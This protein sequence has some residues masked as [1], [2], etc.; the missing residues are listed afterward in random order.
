MLGD[1][2]AH[3][4]RRS[5]DRRG[6]LALFGGGLLAALGGGCAV[7]PVSG[8]PE[9]VVISAE[10]E[11]R[12][13]QEEADKVEREMGVVDDPRLTTYVEALGRRLAAKSPRADVTYTFRIVDDPEPNAF[14]LP[15]GHVYV[16][17]GLLALVNS[18]D[19]LAG[20][21]GHEIGHVAA[22]HSVQQLSRGA[23]LAV[24]S[25]LGGAIPIVGGVVGGAGRLATAAILAPYSREQEHEAD[26][27]GM[28]LA[29]RG[30]WDPAALGRF[31]EVL[32]REQALHGKA[33]GRAGFLSS[34]PSTP[35]RV[36]SVA[37]RARE[38]TR[39]AQAP[40]TP[41]REA[42]FGRLD[43]L[44]VG[45]RAADGVFD[46]QTF[47]HPDLAFVVSFPKGW[48]TD[49]GPEQVAA[50]APDGA[51]LIAVETIASG[52]DPLLGARALEKKSGAP[53]VER[54][55]PAV[56]NGLRA[57]RARV[58]ARGERRR[59]GV[60]L[61]W[62]A[63][64]GRIFQV[65]GVTP[66]ERA[67]ALRPAFEGVVR[68]FRPMQPAERERILEQRLRVAR[69][70]AGET[71]AALVARTGSRWTAEMVAVANQLGLDNR[72]AANQ[73]IKIVVAERYAPRTTGPVPR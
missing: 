19:E 39:T 58:Q 59:L 4:R 17:R 51:A 25:Q 57:A 67:E 55:Q 2:K 12:L 23:P 16:T 44:V 42:F 72:L 71:V 68:T 62:I 69:T 47:L 70:K 63:Y 43:G 46:G 21:I 15:G 11:R 61:A 35:D 37:A 27:I 64:R 24:L 10:D 33:E 26:R 34:H 40:L 32:E 7:N 53:I 1:A 65:T 20:V 28:E 18:E 66:L 50:A 60:E 73:P 29:A 49:N 56:V 48:Q 22:R 45:R 3:H 54:T 5:T 41:S 36:A 38:L 6:F 9:F 14:A 13:G 30:G 8:R 52:D 31:L